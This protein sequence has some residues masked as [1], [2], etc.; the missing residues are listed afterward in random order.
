[1]DAPCTL[2][3]YG[4]A[5]RTFAHAGGWGAAARVYDIKQMTSVYVE[6]GVTGC[7]SLAGALDQSPFVISLVTA[8]QALAVASNAAR[9]LAPGALYCDMNSVAPDTKREAATIIAAAGGAYVDVAIM[10]PVNP[11]RLNVPLLISGPEA[12]AAAAR[13]SMLGFGNLRVTGDSIGTASTIKM[14]RSV[15][16]KGLEALTAEC[17]I[18]CARAGVTGEVIASL[19]AGWGDEANYRLDRM[20]VHGTRR[21]AE[22]AE[23]AKTLEALGVPA[24]L[25]RATVLRQAQIG[26]LGISDP[27]ATLTEKLE[28]LTSQ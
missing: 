26:A 5:G 16:Y 8:D 19:G 3:G 20:M 24:L 7:T 17:L 18:A 15:L 21:S 22:M 10:A 6:D 28:R 9:G 4:E 25:T 27:P 13:L 23:A 14:L 12:T 2:I 11:A 1:M